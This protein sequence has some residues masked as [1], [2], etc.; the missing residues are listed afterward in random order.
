MSGTPK[1]QA[2][3][4]DFDVGTGGTP[5]Q[6][7]V[8]AMP[9]IEED[10]E[11]RDWDVV[12]HTLWSIIPGVIIIVAVVLCMLECLGLRG[13][14]AN[15]VATGRKPQVLCIILLGSGG[16]DTIVWDFNDLVIDGAGNTDTLRVESGDVDITTFAG[17]ITGID[18]VDL[19]ADAGNNA[20][21]V[22]YADVLAMT[23]NADTLVII[24]DVG[25]SIDAGSGW[26]DGGFDGSGNHI[27]TQMVG[28]DLA[29]L[30]VDP[31]V[32][33]NPDILM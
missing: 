31:N 22:S 20:L 18:E 17:T 13:A 4:V 25:D 33:V 21:T 30:L 12:S 29:T 24:G 26:T 16:A 2:D 15:P 9:P 7:D 8:P 23:D 10:D 3:W 6:G 11:M 27:Y 32:T 28:P 14:E 19:S 5:A 1:D